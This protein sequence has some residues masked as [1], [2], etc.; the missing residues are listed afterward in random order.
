MTFTLPQS[1]TPLHGRRLFELLEEPQEPF[2]L[3][4]HLLEKGRS[5]K[6]LPSTYSKA[7][8]N[9]LQNWIQMQLK[10]IASW[11]Q[12]APFNAGFSTELTAEPTKVPGI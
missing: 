8:Y 11:L 7:S 6:L 9:R 12:K 2:L 3:D 5:P 10:S 4:T 1:P